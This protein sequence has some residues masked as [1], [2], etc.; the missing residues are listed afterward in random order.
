MNAVL[1]EAAINLNN[2]HEKLIIKTLKYSAI[3]WDDQSIYMYF[4]CC[5]SAYLFHYFIL[6]F[7]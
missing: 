5:L 1:Y 3:N 2:R 7:F 6:L 4:Y